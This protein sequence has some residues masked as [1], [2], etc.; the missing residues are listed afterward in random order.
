MQLTTLMHFVKTIYIGWKFKCNPTISYISLQFQMSQIY[1]SNWYVQHKF[2]LL[3]L[4]TLFIAINSIIWQFPKILTH[5][6]YKWW[7]FFSTNR[8]RMKTVILLLL[9]NMSS[10]G[11]ILVLNNVII[12]T[13]DHR[14]SS[15]LL[16][17]DLIVVVGDIHPFLNE[18]I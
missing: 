2:G 6:Q 14:Y 8:L 9:T 12:F 17:I 15:I 1:F 16:L 11:C 10:F 7:I 13:L 4:M 3:G 5:F 18:F